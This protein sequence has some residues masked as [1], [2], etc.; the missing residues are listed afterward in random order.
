MGDARGWV[1]SSRLVAVLV[2]V[3]L[4]PLSSVA[5]CP[6][7]CTCRD[8]TLA[9]TCADAGLE[10]VPIQLNPEVEKID[11]SGNRITAVAFTL[12]FYNELRHLDV[13][14]NRIQSLRGKSFESQSRLLFLNA[15][16][17]HITSLGKDAFRGLKSVKVIDLSHNQIETIQDSSF[18]DVH[19]VEVIDLSHNEIIYF[20]EPAVL[21]GVRALKTLYLNHNQMNDV[22]TGLLKNLPSPCSL[23][24]LTLHS[25]LIELIED[26]SFPSSCSNALKILTLGDNVI[27]DIEA[28]A[29]DSVCKLTTLDLSNNNL[30]FVPTQQLSKLNQLTRLD[31]SGNTFSEL[32]PVAFQSLFN[33]RVLRLSR[34]PR[35]RRVDSRTFVDNMHLET[36][37]MEDNPELTRIPTRVFHGNPNLINVSLRGNALTTVDV[38]HFPLDGLKSLD[39]SENPLRCNCS[40]QWLWTLAQME[41]KLAKNPSERPAPPYPRL[42]CA[43]PKH[44][45]GKSVVDLPESAVRCETSWITVAVVTGLMLA[46]FGATC[47]G[48]LL[49]GGSG[50]LCR[51][52]QDPGDPA[53]GDPCRRLPP[54]LHPSPPPPILMLMP[55][56]RYSEDYVKNDADLKYMEPWVG[57]LRCPQN[58]Y[59]PDVTTRK[60]HIVYV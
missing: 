26:K 42:K 20:E 38:S 37:V 34:L 56:K 31:L 54:G 21:K 60:P 16:H 7:R 39:V 33:L 43:S 45:K 9:A 3:L 50:R 6:P 11:L 49:W 53:Q 52:K 15:S 59:S 47:V 29:F 23:E 5:I 51:T 4:V 58:E 25:N 46:L 14:R 17:N 12:S 41:A 24:T 18:K 8:D 27:R 10:V 55:D 13:S 30:T 40:I 19:E 36:I 57:D 22:P 35:M 44:L 2:W 28:A 32:R 48:L 1:P